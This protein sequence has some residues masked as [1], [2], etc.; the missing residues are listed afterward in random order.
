M[1]IFVIGVTVTISGGTTIQRLTELKSNLMSME[2]QRANSPP[3]YVNAGFITP[4][5]VVP[6][7]AVINKRNLSWRCVSGSD[8]YLRTICFPEGIT[9]PSQ[10]AARRGSGTY[11]PLVHISLGSAPTD[12]RSN[13]LDTLQSHF[14]D[15]VGR[16]MV[17][18]EEFI[19]KVKKNTFGFLLGE[20][21]DNVKEH[22][23]AENLYLLAQYWPAQNACEICLLDDGQGVYGSLKAAGRQVRDPHDALQQVLETGLSAKDEF[24]SIT[25]ATGIRNTRRALTNKEIQG[26]FFILSGDSAFLHSSQEGEKLIRLQNFFWNGTIIMLKINRPANIFDMYR[27]VT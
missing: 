24:G 27:Y 22:S 4:L 14:L 18:D 2:F 1:A 5:S 7:A 16:N 19:A 13:Q 17:A 9:D 25:R 11:F 8:S 3:L 15:L 23:L 6:L 21:L 10:A 26:E 12:E 20:M